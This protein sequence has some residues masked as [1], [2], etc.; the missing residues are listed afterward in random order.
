MLTITV[1]G[2]AG[3]QGSKRHVGNGVM[4]ESSHKVKPWREAVKYAALDVATAGGDTRP[5]IELP[6]VVSMTFS[7]ARPK[8]H[9]RTGRNAHL[10]RDGAP[11]YPTSRTHGD[12]SKLARSTEDALV[13]SGVLHDDSL[14][15]NYTRLAKVWAGCGAQ[16]ALGIPGAVIRI[17]PV[18]AHRFLGG[19]SA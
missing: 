10:L 6:V 2:T 9:Y 14:I 4:V 3:P 19:A 13:D 15:V 16:D 8:G 7:F 12:I 1:Y 18:A 5:A 17:T 11:R